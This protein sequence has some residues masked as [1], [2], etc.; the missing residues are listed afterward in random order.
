MKTVDER[1]VGVHMIGGSAA[2]VI[3]D[4]PIVRAHRGLVI[5]RTDV[6][7]RPTGVRRAGTHSGPKQILIEGADGWE[8][9]A[10]IGA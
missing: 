7:A 2:T 6:L 8:V 9:A 5:N 4:A 3:H 1:V 10:R